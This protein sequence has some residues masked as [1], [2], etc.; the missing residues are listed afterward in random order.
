M[1]R[2]VYSASMA[3][4]NEQSTDEACK[5]PQHDNWLPGRWAAAFVGTKWPHQLSL[6]KKQELARNRTEPIIAVLVQFCVM[7][8]E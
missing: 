8:Y 3:A 6:S 5:Q 2:I 7:F 1:V 4:Q